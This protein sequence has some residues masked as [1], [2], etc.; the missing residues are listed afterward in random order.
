MLDADAWAIRV[1]GR[2]MRRH[3]HMAYIGMAPCEISSVCIRD[4][5][6]VLGGSVGVA[7]ALDVL[8]LV[9]PSRVVMLLLASLTCDLCE[10]DHDMSLETGAISGFGT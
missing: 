6:E 5:Q 3:I 7:A 4:P 10:A 8:G 2:F 9:A 1:H